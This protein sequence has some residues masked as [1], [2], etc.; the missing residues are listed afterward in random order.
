MAS[1]IY[2]FNLLTA[3][4]VLMLSFNSLAAPA[5]DWTLQD[6]KGNSVSLQDY[7][8]KVV[9]LHFWATWCPYCKRLQ[10]GLDKLYSEYK[11]K[12]VEL[13]SISFAEDEGAEPQKSIDE[14]GHHFKTLLLGDE[15]AKK[16]QVS[17]TPTTFFIDKKGELVAVTHTSNPDEPG[18]RKIIEQLLKS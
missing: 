11:D 12:G 15:V 2:R 6:A 13:V 8:G 1:P 18:M 7:R 10:P 16:Y 4:F 17:G 9:I 3:I 14:R 5:P